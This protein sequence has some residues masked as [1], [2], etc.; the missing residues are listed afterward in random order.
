MS[1][2][3]DTGLPLTQGK[4]G[5]RRLFELLRKGFPRSFSGRRGKI[6]ERGRTLVSTQKKAKLPFTSAEKKKSVDGKFGRDEIDRKTLVD[7]GGRQGPVVRRRKDGHPT[8]KLRAEGGW[9]E[10]EKESIFNAEEH[11][12]ASV[13]RGGG[14]GHLRGCKK[15]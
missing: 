9:G 7:R 3:G 4:G 2:R 14:G 8:S 6:A 5:A 15:A 10:G 13:R 1:V 11:L 12:Y